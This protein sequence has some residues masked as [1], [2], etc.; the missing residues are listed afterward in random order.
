MTLHVSKP[1][2]K[3]SFSDV[4]QEYFTRM[5]RA[6]QEAGVVMDRWRKLRVRSLLGGPISEVPSDFAESTRADELRWAL[7]K[8][9]RTHNAAWS[10]LRHF[11]P[12]RASYQRIIRLDSVFPVA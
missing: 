9:Y 10:Q 8:C 1:P 7:G 4:S 11:T 2:C 6:T 3:V 5:R 12:V